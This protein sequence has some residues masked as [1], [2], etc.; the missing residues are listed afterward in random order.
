ME[1]ITLEREA[2]RPVRFSGERLAQVSGR[3]VGGTEHNRWYELALYQHE[4]RRYVLAWRYLTLWHGEHRHARV[5][6]CGTLDEA[7]RAFEA[8]DP[9]P[10]IDGYKHLLANNP[11]ER[12]EGHASGSLERQARLE[13]QIGEQY[14][15]LVSELAQALDIAEEL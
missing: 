3:M 8:F 9:L 4:N 1:T 2:L 11:E 14:A 5:E 7:L 10:W 15:A 6:T 13:Q 12:Q